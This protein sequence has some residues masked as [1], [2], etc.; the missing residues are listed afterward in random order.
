MPQLI[1]TD[2]ALMDVQRLYRFLAVKNHD[3]ARRPVQAIR[4][5]ARIIAELP[6]VGKPVS[7]MPESYREWPIDLGDSGYIARY[8]LVG[9]TAVILAV[10]HKR[11]AGQT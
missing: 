9:D 4:I 6:G 11:E 7:D 5:Q 1:W 2:N 10:W 3:A 8:R